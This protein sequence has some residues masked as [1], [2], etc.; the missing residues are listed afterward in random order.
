MWPFKRKKSPGEAEI[1]RAEFAAVIISTVALVFAVGVA[2]WSW[3]IL[4]EQ[5]ELRKEFETLKGRQAQV[6]TQYEVWLAELQDQWKE[7][8]A[9]K[10]AE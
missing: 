10:R 1:S 7:L 5:I 8:E 4:D 9:E 2:R 6:E 3:L